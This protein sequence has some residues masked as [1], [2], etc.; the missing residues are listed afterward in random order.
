MIWSDLPQVVQVATIPIKLMWRRCIWEIYINKRLWWEKST[1]ESFQRTRHKFLK[2]HKINQNTL[3]ITHSI[4]ATKD[5]IPYQQLARGVI[6][7]VVVNCKW[8]IQFP[9]RFPNYGSPWSQ[10]HSKQIEYFAQYVTTKEPQ[11][12]SIQFSLTLFTFIWINSFTIQ[13]F[14]AQYIF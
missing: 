9:F 1:S 13:L 10:N 4:R 12:T 11:G 2:Y 14:E 5:R 7:D 6:K 8:L 3:W